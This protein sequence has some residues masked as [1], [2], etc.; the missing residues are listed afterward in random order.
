MDGGVLEQRERV[1]VRR[2]GRVAGSWVMKM[3][4]ARQDSPVIS[5]VA[6][7]AGRPWELQGVQ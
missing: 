7:L 6:R 2:G 1:R 3:R 5:R 4:G